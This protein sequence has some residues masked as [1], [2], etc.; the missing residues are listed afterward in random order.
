MDTL[1]SDAGVPV[2]RGNMGEKT[3]FS[4]GLARMAFV[5]LCTCVACS[6]AGTAGAP[7]FYRFDDNLDAA[8]AIAARGPASV[9]AGFG[10]EFDDGSPTWSAQGQSGRC[11]IRDGLLILETD[12][13]TAFR[14]PGNLEIDTQATQSILIRLRAEGVKSVRLAWR[15]GTRDD[16]GRKAMYDID[17]PH[18][19]RWW[20]LEI[21]TARFEQWSG[22]VVQLEL[23]V[24]GRGR[25]AIDYIRTQTAEARFAGQEFGRAEYEIGAEI[26]TC[27][28][29]H[30]P[31]EMRYGVR[32]PE[33]GR[34]CVGQGILDPTT[35]VR[36]VIQVKCSRGTE[37]L[38]RREVTDADTWYDAAIDMSDY[39]GQ[40]V[41]IVFKTECD[42]PRKVAF[43]ANPVL[44]QTP[45]DRRVNVVLYLIDALRADHLDVYGYHR[46]TAPNIA[47]FGNREIRFARCFSTNTWTKPSVASLFTGVTMWLHGVQG[48]ADATTD[49]LIT[50]PE[51]LRRNGYATGSVLENSYPGPITN[52]ARGFSN[53]TGPIFSIQD[54]D[55]FES[56]DRFESTLATS[57][58]WID[59]H[60]DRPFFLYVHAMECHAPYNLGSAFLDEYV[61]SGQE[62]RDIDRYDAEIRQADVDFGRFIAGLKQRGLY[63]ETL[64]ILIAD[65]GEGFGEHEQRR[66][67][68]GRPYNDQIH[69]PLIMHVPGSVTTSASKLIEENVCSLDIA[70][71]VLD[72]V[73]IPPVEQFQGISLLQLVNGEQKDVFSDRIILS[74]GRQT[75]SA[76]SGEWKL[77]HD[78]SKGDNSLYNI[79]EDYAETVDL[80]HEHADVADSLL[81][82]TN[83]FIES[84]ESLR[85]VMI[86]E[87][88]ERAVG[89]DTRTIEGLKAL[90]YIK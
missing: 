61:P 56:P 8:T 28:Y 49:S 37:T 16:F 59:R 27:I 69:V 34:L 88:E 42:Q 51:V 46:R 52:L 14:S 25:V 13:R 35:P 4:I 76:I 17:I 32:V 50:F 60:R 3:R 72:A 81:E 29:V 75:V 63:E 78:M 19:N 39:A 70:P 77:L 30:A 54:K 79:V 5:C 11:V 12:Q 44:Y 58:A 23:T 89:F 84:Q 41:D 45:T 38:L 67:H 86:S 57:M 18:E 7:S 15:L 87:K 10:L 36:F 71:T 83:A 47:D 31:S 2:R 62:P 65:H 43:W 1:N 53:V 66:G 90:G 68:A 24:G 22:T 85:T 21:G 26:R 6:C 80:V 40:Q 9:S 48:W 20:V 82:Q 33:R 73:G 74:F 55:R 64:V